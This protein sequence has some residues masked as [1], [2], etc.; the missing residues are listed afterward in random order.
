MDILPIFLAYAD[1]FE[2]TFV[3]DDWSRLTRHFSP[4]AIY[5]ISSDSM[6]ARIQGPEAIFAGMKKSLDGFDRLFDQRKIDIVSAPTV[7][8]ARMTVGW[9][10]TYTKGALPPFVLRGASE[11]EFRDG[12]IVR[13]C[14]SYDDEVTREVLAWQT[15]TGMRFDPSYT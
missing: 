2:K 4:D 13:L 7:D 1:D 15:E 3:D 11:A 8:G 6:P 10:V 5:E 14:D 12:V 9:T